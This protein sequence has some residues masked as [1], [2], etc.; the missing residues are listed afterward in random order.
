[1]SDYEVCSKTQQLVQVSYCNNIYP[2]DISTIS[3]EDGGPVTYDNIYIGDIVR[4]DA[5]T[6]TMKLLP[7]KLQPIYSVSA[8]FN[9]EYAAPAWFSKLYP[10]VRPIKHGERNQPTAFGLKIVEICYLYKKI[11][12][13]ER[14]KGH[15]GPF[16]AGFIDYLIE[17]MELGVF[18]SKMSFY[19]DNASVLETFG[20]EV[21]NSFNQ[22]YDQIAA[23]LN[24]RL[25]F[26]IF[27]TLNIQ[28]FNPAGDTEFTW[29]SWN[30][31]L[32]SLYSPSDLGLMTSPGSLP[33]IEEIFNACAYKNTLITERKPMLEAETVKN[34]VL[35][36]VIYKTCDSKIE[37]SEI[38]NIVSYA[39]EFLSGLSVSV[40][41]LVEK[42]RSKMCSLCNYP[43]EL[44]PLECAHKYCQDCFVGVINAFT[45]GLFVLNELEN[46]KL[47]G[48]ICQVSE[49]N[50]VISEDL[51]KKY[52]PGY[53]EYKN[54]A[55]ERI[56]LKCACGTS[57]K[58]KDFI[59][60]CHHMCNECLFEHL[61]TGETEC[62]KCNEK[63]DESDMKKYKSLKLRCEC[64]RLDRS[65]V[66]CFI[67]KLCSHSICAVCLGETAGMCPID[68][69][70]F[71]GKENIN[72]QEI[73][74]NKCVK[75]GER[76]LKSIFFN[77][78]KACVCQI[79][80]HCQFTNSVDE[81]A[82]CPFKFNE[83]LKLYLMEKRTNEA[84][85]SKLRIKVCLICTEPFPIEVINCLINCDHYFCK[86]C[87]EGNV[88]YLTG[89]NDIDMVSKCPD[90]NADILGVQLPKLVSK[91]MLDKISYLSLIKSTKLVKCP[92]CKTEF[93]PGVQRRVKCLNKPCGNE[94][95]K[96][97]GQPYHENGT[98]QER[99][100]SDRVK[101]LEALDDP[102]GVAQCPRCRLPYIKDDHCEHVKCMS[103]ECGVEFCF[104][105]SCLRKPTMAH[106]NHFHR[107]DCKY[108]GYYNGEDDK[109][110]KDCTE[111]VR[112]G[113]LCK[114][115][116]ALRVPQ[117][118]EPDE[119][120]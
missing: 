113:V 65:I 115:P 42:M 77:T 90:C 44:I 60:K 72:F 98:C 55:D 13:L 107:P 82:L 50:Q 103:S 112:Y 62:A 109:M 53:E 33:F 41:T 108:Y 10:L 93:I 96:E 19:N 66:S 74:K 67:K 88:D 25:K 120:Y 37:N 30:N 89:I 79:C 22:N 48:I 118:V 119:I 47:G 52:L 15:M 14:L 6:R 4:Q 95:C 40:E 69:K 68:F 114:P 63:I 84:E 51:M 46:E 78:A 99:F 26:I 39:I 111:C 1:M 70:P 36:E 49:C 117:R 34:K 110:D 116:K 58:I 76:F 2:I 35:S 23:E 75:C 11:A 97:C 17:N 8:F 57:G 7:P 81:C 12:F 27:P 61:R 105:C 31:C 64:C 9:G 45:Q 83:G 92:E 86:A 56:V 101:D 104:R 38:T 32:F 20:R 87:F 3:T 91:E 80:E 73:S 85:L 16:S 21:L 71:P 24:I 43:K 94:F 28:A 59:I 100:I 106:G 29:L 102:N 5:Q 18:E 54:Q